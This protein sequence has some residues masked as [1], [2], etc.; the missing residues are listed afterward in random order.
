[1][2][3]HLSLGAIDAVL[4][5]RSVRH[6]AAS[7]LNPPLDLSDLFGAEGDFHALEQFFFEKKF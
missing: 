6:I 7:M 5:P 4:C 2:I 3:E 1:M